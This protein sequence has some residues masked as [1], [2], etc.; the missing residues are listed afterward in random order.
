M[1]IYILVSTHILICV[2]EE[3]IDIEE[4]NSEDFY[5][6]KEQIRTKIVQD[7]NDLKRSNSDD[8]DVEVD[9][10]ALVVNLQLKQF[11]VMADDII[12]GSDNSQKILQDFINKKKNYSMLLILTIVII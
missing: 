11:S 6:H 5:T 8:E 10:F 1:V 3:L 7:P 9:K 12:N 2:D 4:F